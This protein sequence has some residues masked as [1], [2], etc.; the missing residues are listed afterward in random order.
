MDFIKVPA[1][2]MHNLS[3]DS[4]N[5]GKPQND[6]GLVRLDLAEDYAIFGQ[7]PPYAAPVAADINGNGNIFEFE[8]ITIVY[9]DDEAEYSAQESLDDLDDLKRPD[10]PK[11]SDDEELDG[12]QNKRIDVA[13]MILAAQNKH[14]D[15]AVELNSQP[16]VDSLHEKKDPTAEEVLK[17]YQDI[18]SDFQDVPILVTGSFVAQMY[19]GQRAAH[20]LDC[21]ST[22]D[23]LMQISNKFNDDVLSADVHFGGDANSGGSELVHFATGVGLDIGPGD[24]YMKAD[25][26]GKIAGESYDDGVNIASRELMIAVSL[27]RNSDAKDDMEQVQLMIDDYGEYEKEDFDKL[28]AP[29]IQDE[30]VNEA[31]K[32]WNS[33]FD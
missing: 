30:K 16:S 29:K 19:G 15:D 31:R 21:M 5:L 25:K 12:A 14:A 28:I 27:C 22:H 33:C 7:N 6:Q 8:D 20:D 18:Q 23:G 24:R 9:D 2:S 17:A 13:A 3:P 4:T 26:D 10:T 1:P 32:L 11:F